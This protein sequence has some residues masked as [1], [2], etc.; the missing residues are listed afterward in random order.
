MK[1]LIKLGSDL[2]SP[3]LSCAHSL[4]VSVLDHDVG[5]LLLQVL[6]DVIPSQVGLAEAHNHRKG[7]LAHF[8]QCGYV[9]QSIHPVDVIRILQVSNVYLFNLVDISI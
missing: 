3:P 7:N 2:I 8:V 4:S 9:S 1:F 6:V 5:A